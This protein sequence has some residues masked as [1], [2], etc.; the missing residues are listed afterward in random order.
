MLLLSWFSWSGCLS[1]FLFFSGVCRG[2]F[3]FLFRFVGFGV[4][5]SC[6]GF[7]RRSFAGFCQVFFRSG[8]RLF[9]PVSFCRSS[10]FGGLGCSC[11]RV[12]RCSAVWGGVV[13]VGSRLWFLGGVLCR[14]A[15]RFLL[16]VSA[17]PGVCRVP[18]LLLPGVLPGLCRLA[19]SPSLSAVR[20]VPMLLS[21]LLVLRRSSCR[22][23]PV[24]SVP[25][26][27]R[28]LVGRRLLFPLCRPVLRLSVLSPL[29]VRLSFRRLRLRLGVS[30]AAAPALGRRSL[31]RR[32]SVWLS[33]SFGLAPALFR[34]RRGA[35]LGLLSPPAFLPALSGLS[36]LRLFFDCFALSLSRASGGGI[37]TDPIAGL[38]PSGLLSRS[39]LYPLPRR[40]VIADGAA[41][42][43]KTQM[44]AGSPRG[45]LTPPTPRRGEH[46]FSIFIYILIIFSLTIVS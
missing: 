40:G 18:P 22:S 38:L 31:W 8:R 6:F 41:I 25:V 14:V 20:R 37:Y 33:L 45:A 35:A 24:V 17:V 12:L 16:S 2:F 9:F 34:L 1:F 5:C 15:C 26:V 32:V 21:V 13:C 36:L 3:F 30:A 43:K 28:S 4:C 19:A 7:L 10:L 44:P 23:L 42:G 29:R 27:L 39:A 11:W 46:I